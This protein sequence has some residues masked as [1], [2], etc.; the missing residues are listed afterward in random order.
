MFINIINGRSKWLQTMGMQ[1]QF[2][3]PIISSYCIVLNFVKFWLNH[4]LIEILDWRLYGV[5]LLTLALQQ[6]SQSW[7]LDT[8]TNWVVLGKV[9]SASTQRTS[10]SLWEGQWAFQ[11]PDDLGGLTRALMSSSSN[12][13]ALYGPEKMKMTPLSTWRN[14]AGLG[15]QWWA[16]PSLVR[17]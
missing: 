13:G 10:E 16:F 8:T 1:K 5:V 17:Q 14:L 3:H 7:N 4:I 6:E 2:C 12:Q 9:F 15:E 11:H